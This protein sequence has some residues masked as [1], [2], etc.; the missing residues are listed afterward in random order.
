VTNTSLDLSAFHRS[1]IDLSFLDLPFSEEVWATIK[2]VPVDRVPG[3]DGYTGQFYKSC[4]S[5]I[6]MDFMVAILT[7]QQG[8]ARKLEQL[9]YAFLT[10]IPKKTEALETKD[11]RPISLVHSCTKLV[12]KLM[13][14]RLAPHLN[15][16]IDTNQSAFI[17]GRCIHDN[18]M[19]VQQTIKRLHQ[20][21][22]ASLF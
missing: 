21:K 10:L 12:T 20:R 8:D 1:G 18:F 15:S 5:V 19:L 17:R 16:L 4:W 13:V 22:I 6:K 14:K 7:L 2:S 9:N 3:P 11:Y